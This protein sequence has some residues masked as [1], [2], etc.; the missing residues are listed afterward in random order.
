MKN[1]SQTFVKYHGCGNSFLDGT[2]MQLE[3][4]EKCFLEAYNPCWKKPFNSCNKIAKSTRNKLK[5]KARVDASYMRKY[6][7]SIKNYSLNCSDYETDEKFSDQT[8]N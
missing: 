2:N 8:M 6:F 7:K 5:T 4:G 1:F 3:T